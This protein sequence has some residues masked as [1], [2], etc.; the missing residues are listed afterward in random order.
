MPDCS[1]RRVVSKGGPI[2]IHLRVFGRIS[3]APKKITPRTSAYRLPG[4][5]AKPSLQACIRLYQGS[6]VADSMAIP[7]IWKA[8]EM[9]CS[10]F[11]KEK[12]QSQCVSIFPESP[13]PDLSVQSPS[14]AEVEAVLQQLAKEGE[15]QLTP[16]H[17]SVMAKLHLAHM[18]WCKKNGEDWH[19]LRV[20]DFQSRVFGS[21]P[22]ALAMLDKLP[23]ADMEELVGGPTMTGTF[24]VT[25]PQEL[26]LYYTQRKGRAAGLKPTTSSPTSPHVPAR[27]H[28]MLGVVEAAQAEAERLPLDEKVLYTS[29][30]LCAVT[31]KGTSCAMMR[32][33]FFAVCDKLAKLDG[34]TV[35]VPGDD[36]AKVEAVKGE[37]DG[38]STHEQGFPIAVWEGQQ[39]ASRPAGPG[40]FLAEQWD[41]VPPEK[42]T[43]GKIVTKKLSRTKD[44]QRACLQL[45]QVCGE[46][47]LA[48]LTHAL[49]FTDQALWLLEYEPEEGAT[50]PKAASGQ[51]RVSETIYLNNIA[52]SPVACVLWHLRRAKKAAEA[53]R[54]KR[55]TKAMKNSSAALGPEQMTI[56]Q[57]DHLWEALERPAS[58][59]GADTVWYGHQLGQGS[60]GTVFKGQLGLGRRALGIPVPVKQARLKRPSGKAWPTSAAERLAKERDSTSAGP[61]EAP[62]GVL[63]APD[64]RQRLQ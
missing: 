42:R 46:M 43:Y 28:K 12:V 39:Q 32:D 29:P 61:P 33:T 5:A 21:A 22:A 26:A 8:S 38:Y 11:F 54:A 35:F 57:A 27:V 62:S 37:P 18:R 17:R 15:P 30:V 6:G 64:L 45:S 1:L 36:V 49:L 58:G 2:C 52:Q 4:V 63:S 60:T 50:D 47:H 48:G 9:L 31:S 51:L 56:L 59:K 14:K 55:A 44:P 19:E 20:I 10:A 24:H 13:D 3:L 41:K 23:P 40:H 7:T 16:Q 25:S 34:L 53:R